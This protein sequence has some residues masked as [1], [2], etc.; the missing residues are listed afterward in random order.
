[1]VGETVTA[2]GM[3]G[4][5]ATH[6]DLAINAVAAHQNS[7]VEADPAAAAENPPVV[8]FE[9]MLAA[10]SSQQPMALPNF[11]LLRRIR[12]R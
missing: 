8:L 1:M 9:T 2:M 7:Q 4:I 6:V 11:G 10:R 12:R 3:P 5:T